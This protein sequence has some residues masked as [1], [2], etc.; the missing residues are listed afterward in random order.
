MQVVCLGDGLS[1]VD[2]TVMS[3]LAGCA[4]YSCCGVSPECT[5]SL[6]VSGDSLDVSFPSPPFLPVSFSSGHPL[7]WGAEADAPFGAGVVPD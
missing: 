6:A 5:S 2:V 7:W 3:V 1:E 4:D